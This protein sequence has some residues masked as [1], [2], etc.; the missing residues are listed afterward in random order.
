M[1]MGGGRAFRGKLTDT[2]PRAAQGWYRGGIP[3]GRGGPGEIQSTR[4]DTF[5]NE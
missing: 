2:C 1:S 3:W 4:L 5:T